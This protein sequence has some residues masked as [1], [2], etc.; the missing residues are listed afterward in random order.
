[1]GDCG[2]KVKLCTLIE[3][4]RPFLSEFAT[5]I[6]NV[7]FSLFIDSMNYAFITSILFLVHVPL[8]GVDSDFSHSSWTH[9]K[10]VCSMLLTSFPSVQRFDTLRE[11]PALFAN[12][13]R[14]MYILIIMKKC[15]H[16]SGN[17]CTMSASA[18]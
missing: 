16:Y 1:M 17:V 5:T 6:G 9:H 10:C 8:I 13:G 7:I 3:E 18:L 14:D 15:L 2:G 11:Y 12:I 4:M